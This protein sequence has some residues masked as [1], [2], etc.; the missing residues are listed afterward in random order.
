M[1]YV[2][3]VY[4]FEGYLVIFNMIVME[5]RINFGYKFYIFYYYILMLYMV[6]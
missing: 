3:F 2:I 1:F 6:I 5:V 4:N